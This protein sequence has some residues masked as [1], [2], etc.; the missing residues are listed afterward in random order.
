M[1]TDHSAPDV[2]HA[3][4]ERV[5]TLDQPKTTEVAT[6]AGVATAL[7]GYHPDAGYPRK[8]RGAQIARM[9]RLVGNNGVNRSLRGHSTPG[10]RIQRHPEG[11][12]MTHDPVEANEEIAN[13]ESLGPV[14]PTTTADDTATSTGT[15]TAS[16]TDAAPEQ[17]ETA[18]PE[19]E[20]D[21]STDTATDTSDIPAATGDGTA[22]P[23]PATNKVMDLAKAQDVLTK[24]YGK[25][26]TIVA[27]S[28]EMLADRE[29][30][31]K[32]YDEIAKDATN[33]HTGKKWEAGDAKKYIPGLDG[34]ASGGKVY[35][36]SQTKLATATAHEMLHNNTASDFRGKVGE[37]INEGSTETLAIKALKAASVSTASG[38][39][40][41]GEVAFV[42]KLI[43]LVSEQTLIDAY[44]GGA[45][46]L[47]DKFDKSQGAGAF[48]KMKPFAEA[49]NYTEAEKSLA[50]VPATPAKTGT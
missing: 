20:T 25:N 44:F 12:E 21:T 1:G 28:I 48:A 34:F 26:K 23:A 5:R 6:A 32:K 9:Q 37:T 10:G 15:D 31:W 42:G 36:N 13:P 19:P 4:A 46:T 7:T 39:A 35:I 50:P 27:G 2:S 3:T 18:P 8:L 16:D 30:T 49:K 11:A 38:T 40:Y 47:I 24:S 33:P 41:P 14:G 45:A 43:N 22:P 17:A 29:A